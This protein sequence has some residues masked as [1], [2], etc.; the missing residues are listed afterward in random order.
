MERELLAQRSAISPALS[1]DESGDGDLVLCAEPA[2]ES[3]D[4][5]AEWESDELPPLPN[6]PPIPRCPHLL[7]HPLRASAWFVRNG[8]GILALVGLWAIVAAIPV[9]QILAL[10]YLLEVEGRVARRGRLRDAFPM[11]ELCAPA[12]F[13]CVGRG[14][15]AAAAVFDRQLRLGCEIDRSREPANGRLANGEDGR[16][17]VDRN[18]SLPGPRAGREFWVLLSAA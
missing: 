15:L 16:V 5:L 11:L 4:H 6:F 13:H 8:L 12:R 18:P 9:V 14:V 2:L 3:A 1:E 7:K 10:G 17:G